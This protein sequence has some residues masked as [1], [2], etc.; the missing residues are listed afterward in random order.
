MSDTRTRLLQAALAQYQEFGIRGVT[1]PKVARRAG[2]RGSHLTYFFPKKADLL[3]AVLEASHADVGG[4]LDALSTADRFELLYTVALEARKSD[5]AAQ[6]IASH[7]SGFEEALAGRYGVAPGSEAIRRLVDE[8]RG[9][10]VRALVSG[11][12]GRSIDARA[13]RLGLVQRTG[14]QDADRYEQEIGALVPGYA[15]IHE[16]AADYLAEASPSGR[17]LISGC[18]PGREVAALATAL[19][20]WHLDAVDPS[21]GMRDAARARCRDLPGVHVLARPEEGATYDAV[22]SLFVVHLLEPGAQ[23]A[24]WAS[25]GQAAR[26]GAPVVVAWL[27]QVDAPQRS[28]WV[29][30]AARHLAPER[31][32]LLEA[33]LTTAG[34]LFLA[35]AGRQLEHAR[36]AGLM[37]RSGLAHVL[38]VRLTAFEKATPPG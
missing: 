32:A 16:L 8:I 36:A 18:G 4:D 21:E 24:Y 25:L 22:L 29:R 30:H 1:Q 14:F 19:P 12:P 2:L 27:H 10:G 31:V 7:L 37:P 20:G 35:P 26:E 23:A 11:E 15:L 17:L 5:D 38:G 3:A 6:A 13:A 34:P 33:R 28:A 9:S